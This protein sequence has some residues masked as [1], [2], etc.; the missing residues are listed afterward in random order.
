MTKT[1]DKV[2]YKTIWIA[3]NGVQM[4]IIKSIKNSVISEMRENMN[5]SWVKQIPM[6]EDMFLKF[7]NTW[8]DKGNAKLSKEDITIGLMQDHTSFSIQHIS[9][10]L[11]EISTSMTPYSNPFDYNHDSAISSLKQAIMHLEELVLLNQEK[12]NKI[13]KEI[14]SIS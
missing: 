11:S 6:P 14:K 1:F 13:E 3:E 9:D 7:F 5:V 12:I 8:K 2:P 4:R 10:A